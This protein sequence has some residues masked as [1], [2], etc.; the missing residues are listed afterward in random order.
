[1]ARQFYQNEKKKFFGKVTTSNLFFTIIPNI[2][3]SNTW[4]NKIMQHS[5]NR[6]GK[7]RCFQK[8]YQNICIPCLQ[9]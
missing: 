2:R 6:R 8:Y 9:H 5:V 7:K 4:K 1:M 3:K